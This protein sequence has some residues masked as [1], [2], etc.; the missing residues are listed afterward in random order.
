MSSCFSKES[1]V[2]LPEVPVWAVSEQAGRS[3]RGKPN[4]YTTSELSQTDK[5][6]ILDTRKTQNEIRQTLRIANLSCKETKLQ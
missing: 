3:A 4:T 6:Q 2:W 5:I 1:Q